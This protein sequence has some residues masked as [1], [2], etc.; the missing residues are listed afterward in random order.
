MRKAASFY[1]EKFFEG[2]SKLDVENGVDD[3]VQEAVNVASPNSD[4][5]DEVR[6]VANAKSLPGSEFQAQCIHDVHSEERSPAQQ[7]HS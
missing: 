3:G 5:H 1:M 4:R 7:E 6:D 2:F